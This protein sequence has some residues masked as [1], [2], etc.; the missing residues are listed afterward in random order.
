MMR[1]KMRDKRKKDDDE[2]DVEI[3]KCE[4]S[5]VVIF[6]LLLLLYLLSTSSHPNIYIRAV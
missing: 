4:L 2:D 5:Q 1:D 3:L 6:S